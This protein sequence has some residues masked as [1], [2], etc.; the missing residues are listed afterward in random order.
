MNSS[1][2]LNYFA[3]FDLPVTLEVDPAELRRR[4]LANSKKF[5][6]DY[7]TLATTEEQE[8]ALEQSSYNNTAF[9][10]LQDPD[11]RLQYV[12]KLTGVLGE[13]AGNDEIEPV[14]LMEMMEINEKIMELEFDPS[15]GLLEEIK[16]SVNQV[17]TALEGSVAGVKQS[18]NL[19]TGSRQDLGQ[20]KSYFLKKK[21][22]LR[23]KENLSK[24]AAAFEN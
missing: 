4:F 6:P 22:L 23:V 14:F 16:A 5:H 1:D 18:W 20:L 17:E 21:Y 12:L 8:R 24:F 11:L 2:Q 10:T 7:H 19:E 3:Y 13:S 15:A 9:K